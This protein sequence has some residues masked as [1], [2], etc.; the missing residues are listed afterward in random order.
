MTL[1]RQKLGGQ[2]GKKAGGYAD[3]V[4]VK[5]GVNARERSDENGGWTGWCASCEWIS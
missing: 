3:K 2:A 4:V 5:A 1:G